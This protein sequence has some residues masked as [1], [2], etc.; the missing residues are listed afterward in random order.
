VTLNHVPDPFTTKIAEYL[1]QQL[2]G[3]G[4]TITLNP[5]QQA[6]IINTA[7]LG[8]F[9]AQVWRQFGAIDPD[10][11]YIF[12]S[13][14][15]INS[16][17]SINMARNTDQAVETAVQKGRQTADPAA[18][19]AAYQEV[20]SWMGK[21]IPYI[22]ADRTVWSIGAQPK[23]QN[24]DNPILPEGGKAFGMITGAIWPTQV[25]IGS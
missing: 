25:W 19:A 22:W 1:Q 13:P 11:N 20:A 24:F 9:E 14:T 2:N 18:R 17:Y 15:Q 8:G 21:D 12:W 10:L 7:L 4:M 23:V 3:V 16:V 5:V 6:Q